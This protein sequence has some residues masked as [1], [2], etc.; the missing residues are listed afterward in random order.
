MQ[1]GSDPVPADLL[2]A[3]IMVLLMITGAYYFR[4]TERTIVDTL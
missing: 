1:T 4:R 3:G 2:V